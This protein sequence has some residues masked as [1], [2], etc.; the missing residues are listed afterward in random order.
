MAAIAL[1]LSVYVAAVLQTT[2]APAME[3]RGVAP[4]FFVVVA[5]VWSVRRTSGGAI[6]GA[7]AIGLAADLTSS[8][9]VGVNIALFVIAGA[10]LEAAN[11]RLDIRHGP[12]QLAMVAGAALFVTAGQCLVAAATGE[13]ALDAP[14]LIVRIALS[15]AYTTLI[16]WPA[17]AAMAR[18]AKP[19]RAALV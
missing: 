11:A 1:L 16:G 4:S 19:A 17:L 13:V 6:L 5:L 3:W 8:G 2:L 14:T 18:F 10:A 15:A 7:A 12:A 9:V